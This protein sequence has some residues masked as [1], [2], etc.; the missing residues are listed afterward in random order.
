MFRLEHYHREA[1][2]A[3]DEVAVLIGGQQRD[4]E[5]IGIGQIDTQQVAGLSLDHRPGGHAADFRI[6][7][8]AEYAITQITVSDQAPTGYR[9]T[10]GHVIG[11]QEYLLRRV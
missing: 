4:V 9:A 1:I 2:G 6:V 10:R 5:H 7:S 3:F 8:V 11:T